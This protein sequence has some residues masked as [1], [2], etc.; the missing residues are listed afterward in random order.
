MS[1]V[2][3]RVREVLPS[4]RNYCQLMVA[5][6]GKVRFVCLFV[7]LRVQ[8]WEDD[9]TPMQIKESLNGL[10]GFFEKEEKSI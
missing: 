4:L 1:M 6:R 9:L 2:E 8:S 3:G 10:S 5:R 7:C